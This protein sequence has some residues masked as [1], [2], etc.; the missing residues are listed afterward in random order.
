MGLLDAVG[1]FLGN[2]PIVGDIITGG[3]SYASAQAQMDFQEE[4]SRTAHQREV[5]DLIKAGL[6]P[7]L[8]AKY[9]G[10][11][12]PAGA[13]WQ[14]PLIGSSAKTVAESKKTIEETKN[15][16][17]ELK[18]LQA[19]EENIMANTKQ[20]LSNSAKNSAEYN[21]I[22]EETK[23]TQKFNKI[24]DSKVEAARIEAEIDKTTYGKV[25]RYLGRL[26]PFSSSAVDVNAIVK[27]AK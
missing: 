3:A 1:D 18:N 23:N 6:N 27:G 8:S 26:N 12:T 25:L 9:G 2:V 17:Q 13:G 14:M 7:V 15:K 20:A 21:K 10:A 4:L 11:S 19:T 5:E 22:L 24:M 16:K